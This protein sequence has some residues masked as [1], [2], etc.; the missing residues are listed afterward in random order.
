MTLQRGFRALMVLAIGIVPAV[1]AQQVHDELTPRAIS[2][3]TYAVRVALD[4]LAESL[5]RGAPDP[6]WTGDAPLAAAVVDLTRKASARA[7]RRPH[8][9]LGAAWD[10]QLKPVEFVANGERVLHVR[11][12]VYLATE[13][14]T[15]AALVRLTFQRHGDGWYFVE[16]E[17]LT[18]RLQAIANKLGRTT[19][20]E[21]I[22][23]HLL[24][25]RS[26]EWTPPSSEPV[27]PNLPSDPSDPRSEV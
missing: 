21:A 8:P 2:D 26:V 10:L 13:P 11:A 27:R 4:E 7:P 12:Q 3:S 15:S 20:H 17:G 22:R 19:L 9:E 25:R 6:R 1:P 16:Q 18:S 14:D 5:R 24:D 23:G